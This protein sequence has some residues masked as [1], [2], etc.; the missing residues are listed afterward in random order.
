MNW[1]T[2]CCEGGDTVLWKRQVGTGIWNR[3]MNIATDPEGKIYICDYGANIYVYS[4]DGEPV[5]NLTTTEINGPV[6]VCTN[7]L[8]RYLC[9]ADL[10]YKV[11]LLSVDGS[12]VRFLLYC[13]LGNVRRMCLYHDRY[14][15]VGTDFE[16]R[17]YDISSVF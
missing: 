5:K 3:H 9:V 14:L 1:L 13:S 8:G 4:P 15:A 17:L 6:A 2:K 7:S 16:L 10:K 11:S 12:R